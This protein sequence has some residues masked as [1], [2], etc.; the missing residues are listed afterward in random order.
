MAEPPKTPR[1]VPTPIPAGREAFSSLPHAANVPGDFEAFCDGVR[2]LIGVD[3]TH[4]KRNQMERRARG[5][6][7]RHNAESLDGYLQLLKT[8]DHQLDRFIERMTITVSRLWR[9]TDIFEAVEDLI[10]PELNE[11]AGARRLQ[12]W[13]AGCSYG[14]EPYTLAVLCMENKHKLDRL[15]TLLGTDI[16]PRMI[17]RA[18]RGYFTD[19]DARD[20]PPLL[21]NKYFERGSG[22]WT[23]GYDLKQ[24]IRFKV[25]DLFA[26]KTT[27][28]DLILFRNVAI[29]FERPKREEI[30]RILADALVP[31]GMLVLGSTEM[32]VHPVDLGLERVRPFVFRKTGHTTC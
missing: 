30:H 13:S 16:N 31:G 21:L 10:L 22:G 6:A 14:A 8:D 32:I 12:F 23:A 17:D 29:H 11:L 28:M 26:A 4:Y 25:Q 9:N 20:A 5:L 24:M 15:P 1:G 27:G 3:L 18:K 2:D 7:S 19:E